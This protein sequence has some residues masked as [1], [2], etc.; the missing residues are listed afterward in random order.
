MLLFY[1]YFD[2]WS[3]SPID[4]IPM[5]TQKNVSCKCTVDLLRYTATR[6]MDIIACILNV[7]AHYVIAK[8]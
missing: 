3:Q 8:V 4:K 1:N 7:T 5:K 2:V 6:G